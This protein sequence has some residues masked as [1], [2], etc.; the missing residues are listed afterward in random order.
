MPQVAVQAMLVEEGSPV[1][2]KTLAESALRRT[3]GL[4]VIAISRAGETLASPDADV[5]L[6]PGDIAYVF[7]DIARL[8]TAA[9]PFIAPQKTTV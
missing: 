8:H 3:W 1:A 2:G 4:T 7:A 6:L 5:R 9:E